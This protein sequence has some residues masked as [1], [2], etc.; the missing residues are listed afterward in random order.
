MKRG[1][2]LI[3]FAAAAALALLA[4]PASADQHHES[5]YLALGDSVPFGYNPL[6]TDPS[7]PD[8]FVGYPELLRG[9]L[10][11][12]LANASCP[13][14]TTM[15]FIS[16]AGLDD[17]CGL[18]RTFLPLHVRYTSSQL[19]Y[20]VAFLH[21][22]ANTRLVTIMVGADDLNAFAVVC[23]G[24]PSCIQND[25]LTISLPNLAT[26]FGTI[27]S[28]YQGPLVVVTYYARNNT[29][30]EIQNVIQGNLL[31]AGVAAQ[32]QA[33]VAD[34]FAAFAAM[35]G[36]SQD[37]CAA[38]LLIKLPSGS[39]DVHPSRLGHR[40]LARAVLTQ[41]PGHEDNNQT[42]ASN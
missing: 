3:A 27:R 35:E 20:A 42:G 31:I 33:R 28:V 16:L 25:I 23:G 29:A 2:R 11:A 5:T 15:H 18:F 21:Q 17:S 24:V 39:C 38:G 9:R 26:I 37:P 34:G 19:D 30:Q 6:V 41:I 36:P 12:Q 1:F 13:G 7:D 32:F 14:E 40:V 4:V 22:H 8:N 10:D